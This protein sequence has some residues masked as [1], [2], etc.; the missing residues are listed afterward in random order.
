MNL[1]PPG[2]RKPITA[3]RRHRLTSLENTE[4]TAVLTIYEKLKKGRENR[5][6]RN[7]RF[8][9]SARIDIEL[10]E[11]E[12]TVPIVP[13]FNAPVEI[14][15]KTLLDFNKYQ[16]LRH[17]KY[18]YFSEKTRLLQSDL[19]ESLSPTDSNYR[20]LLSGQNFWLNIF[21]P[22][23]QDFNLLFNAYGVHDL[24]INDIREGN[25]EDKV[26]A[27]KHYTFF[28][29]RLMTEN[30]KDRKENEDID[31]NILLFKDFIITMHDKQWVGNLDVLGFLNLLITHSR[32]PLTPDWV[33]FSCFIEMNQ[34]AKYAIQLLEP[35]INRIRVETKEM[36]MSDIMRRIFE[37]E[38]QVYSIGRFVKPKARVLRHLKVKCNK[39]IN[40]IVMNLLNDISDDFR[41]ITQDLSHFNH[42]LERSQD[43]FLA[44]VSAD[45]S[46]E[47]NEMSL[48]MK[49]ISEFA[50][51][52][53]PMQAISGFFGMNVTVP[54]QTETISNSQ[55]PFWVIVGCCLLLGVTMYFLRTRILA[56]R[57]LDKLIRKQRSK[58]AD[59]PEVLIPFHMKY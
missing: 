56:A 45:Q 22:N 53:I 37:L 34:D 57:V 14:N 6:F 50:L 44:I 48:V 30:I 55:I 29:L 43:T 24:T 28:S 26:E 5:V 10:N 39:R 38:L 20:D 4:L 9:A 59:S 40:R 8:D 25:T 2:Y 17:T 11:A 47:A 58:R 52:F 46:R 16:N 7:S 21:D 41:D 23:E 54:F 49:R 36:E 27:F 3:R 13:I 31:F 18:F 1:S 12:E 32:T 15:T 19:L 42:I 35:V 51:V 33:M